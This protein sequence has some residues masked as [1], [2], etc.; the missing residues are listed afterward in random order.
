MGVVLLATWA[1]SGS[2]PTANRSAGPGG[3]G[4]GTGLVPII[5][6]STQ[7]PLTSSPADLA[8]GVYRFGTSGAPPTIAVGAI[9]IGP[10]HGGFLRRVRNVT[11]SGGSI[12]LATDPASLTDLVEDGTLNIST[13][14]PIATRRGGAGTSVTWGAISARAMVPGVSFE[15][16]EIILDQVVLWGSSSAGLTIPSGSIAFEPTVG[17]TVTI[18]D[19]A[20]QLFDARIGGVVTAQAGLQL[21]VSGSIDAPIDPLTILVTKQPFA[22]T[23]PILGVPI[24]VYGEAIET[25]SLV[26]SFSADAQATV[27]TGLTVTDTVL[28]GVHYENGSWQFVTPGDPTDQI[29]PLSVTVGGDASAK[30]GLKMDGQLLLYGTVAPH[31][32]VEPYLKAAVSVDLAGGRWSSSC[33]SAINAGV[34]VTA[35]ILSL[36]LADYSTSADFFSTDWPVCAQSGALMAAGRLSVVSG[37]NQTASAGTA[38]GQPVVV[39]LVSPLGQPLSGVGVRFAALGDG[40]TSPSSSATDAQ[41]RAATTWIL[42][43]APGIDTL[44]VSSP[45]FLDSPLP[46][47]AIGSNTLDCPPVP[48]TLGTVVNGDI[49]PDDCGFY[50]GDQ[51]NVGRTDAFVVTLPA[52]ATLQLNMNASYPPN[53]SVNIEPSGAYNDGFYAAAGATSAT[54]KAI[55]PAGPLYIEANDGAPGVY[56][57]YSFSVS[58]ASDPDITNCEHVVLAANVSTSQRLSGTDCV[59]AGSYHSD[60]Y[61]IAIP[62]LWTATITMRSTA[63]DAFLELDD[64][65]DTYLTSDDDG[66]GGQDAQIVYTNASPTEFYGYYLHAR[67]A[68]A[69]ATGP[70]TLQLE[71]TPPAGIAAKGPRSGRAPMTPMVPHRHGP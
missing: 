34:G 63:F 49:T 50:F 24:P 36:T 20:V 66:G 42:K 12:A 65:D 56:G 67:S 47:H 2:Q 64:V 30:L 19:G 17:L 45:G 4:T 52:A 59:D 31:L 44:L 23:I 37:D 33:T 53:L 10:Q 26:P 54:G 62:P 71:L 70:Y 60:R 29:V 11:Q 51:N 58:T 46:V 9:I 13:A 57:S 35:K 43:S 48:Y 5:I 27:A 21:G 40:A 14:V 61:H 68:H 32:W 22:T 15:N 6:D 8:Q 39:Q 41:G 55:V 25:Y 1:C 16:G 28:L 38:L 69:D 18:H 3:T 7:M